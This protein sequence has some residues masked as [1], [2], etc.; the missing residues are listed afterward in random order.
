[1]I[2][3]HSFSQSAWLAVTTATLPDQV[4]HSPSCRAWRRAL[5][6][7]LSSASCARARPLP[8]MITTRCG[9]RRS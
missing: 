8:S 7:A 3:W 4:S 1:M 2:A 5:S 6:T 9:R